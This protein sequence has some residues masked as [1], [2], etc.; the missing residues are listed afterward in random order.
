MKI[1]SFLPL[2]ALLLFI[3]LTITA[4]S[5][6]IDVSI[7]GCSDSTLILGYY[8]NNK[9]LVK[10]TTYINNDG[11]YT[12]SGEDKLDE[13]IYIVYLQNQSYFDVLIGQDQIFSINTKKN[14]LLNQMTI[15]GAQ[16]SSDFLAYQQF[17]VSKQKEAVQLQEQIKAAADAKKKEELQE[18]IKALSFEVKNKYK[19]IVK[20]HPNSFVS[21][22]LNATQDIEVP[23]MKAPEN[24][25]N[26]DSVVQ[27]LRYNY[28]KAHYFDNLKMDDPRLLRTPIFTSKLDNYFQKVLIQIP[29]TIIK[30][31]HRVIAM[32][33][34]NYEME[35]YLIQ[36][37][38]NMANE[39]KIMGMDAVMVDLGEVYYLSG[40]ADWVDDE[41]LSKLR[42]RVDKIK[43][44][45]IG[46]AAADFK[47]QSY[48]EEYFKLSEIRANITILVFWEPECGHCEKEIPKLNEDVW[49]KYKD[50]DIKIVAV[51]T[52]IDQ[53]SW[54]EFIHNHELDEWIHLYD[55]Y[56]QSNFRNN[57]DIYSTPVIYI[58]DKDKNILAK[59]I[60][61]E[62]IPGFLD[63]HFKIN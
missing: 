44:N 30:E 8:F 47:M 58:L 6:N 52:Q 45:I 60:G 39:S 32:A 51:Y 41:F 19:D 49:R 3:P 33:N 12:F 23:Q 16:E 11:T 15:K 35:K 48:T 9:M 13:G 22:F 27:R 62:Q 38:F 59:R 57:Y 40:R 24:S 37:L 10:D 25:S 2:Y 56:N 20:V 53:D 1:K 14:D 42:E 63:H 46:H 34:A 36:H 17:L 26:P 4:Q 55:P 54:I 18:E 61:A 29:D 43:P 7:G 28:Y 21:I 5:Y 50:Q 31:A